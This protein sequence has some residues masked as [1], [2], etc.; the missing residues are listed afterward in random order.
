VVLHD[1]NLAARYCDRLILLN[2]GEVAAAGPTDEVLT[3]QVLE[4]VYGIGVRRLDEPDCTQLIFQPQVPA[5]SGIRSPGTDPAE[6]PG[7]SRPL[8]GSR[9]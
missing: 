5:G 2:H 9:S 7:S 1:L 8:P 4:P 3:P 6:P